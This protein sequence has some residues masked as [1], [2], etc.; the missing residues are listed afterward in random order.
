[1]SP[2]GTGPGTKPGPSVRRFGPS[3]LRVLRRTHLYLGLLLWPFALFFGITALS[4]NHPTVGRG[5]TVQSLPAEMVRDVTGFRPWAPE[6]VAG[7]VVTE[8]N[9]AGGRYRLSDGKAPHFSG[10]PLFA[11]P[12]SAG[13]QVLIVNLSSG[14]ATLTLRPEPPAEATVELSAEPLK[15]RDYDLARLARQL[16]PVLSGAGSTAHGVLRPHPEAHPKL[17]FRVADARERE[18]NVVYDLASGELWAR[19][20]D[21]P[22]SEPLV[23]LLERLHT[24]HHYPPHADATTVWALFADLTALTLITWALT[25]LVMWW[26]LKRL[27]RIGAA[28]IAVSL[29][30]AGGVIASTAAE[31]RF[32]PIAED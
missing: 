24:Q 3:A 5:L 9:A 19:P 13:K 8:L 17:H 14:S 11:A 2:S 20:T 25:G 27:R 31:L 29:A 15:L 21:E 1:M 32:G 26:Q 28:V 12:V 7:A 6:R 23:A 22:R 10:F 16:S 30:L 18:L 4:F